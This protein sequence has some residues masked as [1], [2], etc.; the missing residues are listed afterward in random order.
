MKSCGCIAQ[1]TGR[2]NKN[3]PGG[4][5]GLRGVWLALLILRMVIT[6]QLTTKQSKIRTLDHALSDSPPLT[7][8][9]KDSNPR[10]CITT[11]PVTPKS[12]RFEP[13]TMHHTTIDWP[14]KSQFELTTMHSPPLTTKSQRFEPNAMHYT[15][16]H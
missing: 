9:I 10:P 2:Y 8:K 7:K 1:Y 16:D 6:P 14:P 15:T 5:D 4:L 13:M 3:K 12:K 11:P